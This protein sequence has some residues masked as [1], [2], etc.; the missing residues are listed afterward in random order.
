LIIRLLSDSPSIVN[1]NIDCIACVRAKQHKNP[2]V[3]SSMKKGETI[4]SILSGQYTDS[5]DKSKYV[6][7]FL[8]DFTHFCCVE[9]I[10]NK[11]LTLFGTCVVW[12]K[13]A[14]ALHTHGGGNTREKLTSYLKEQPM[15]QQ[16]HGMIV[17]SLKGKAERLHGTLAESVRAIPFQHTELFWAEPL[18]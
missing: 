12:M 6:I 16:P 14:N 13:E 1:R 3:T 4:H 8:D 15:S 18:L 2:F 7:I 5:K 10:P 17:P 11:D 9:T